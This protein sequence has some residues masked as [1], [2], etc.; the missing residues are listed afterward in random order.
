VRLPLEDRSHGEVEFWQTDE[1]GTEINYYNVNMEKVRVVKA[2]TW[3]PNVDD[4]KNESFKHMM[5]YEL[6]YDKIEWVFTDG[7]LAFSDQWKKPNI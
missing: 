6:R 1:T 4:K 7:N 2:E 3:F 5:T